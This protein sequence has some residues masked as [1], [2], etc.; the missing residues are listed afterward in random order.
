MMLSKD[1]QLINKQKFDLDNKPI[2]DESVIA[3]DDGIDIT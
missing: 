3:Q 1:E 2:I